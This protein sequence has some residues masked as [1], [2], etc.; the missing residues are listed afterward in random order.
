MEEADTSSTKETV[1]EEL[2]SVETSEQKKQ[3]KTIPVSP[4]ASPTLGKYKLN[5]SLSLKSRV[6]EKSADYNVQEDLSGK[7]KDPFTLDTLQNKWHAYCHT[8]K[9]EGKLGLYTT[10][11][12]NP[13]KL[14][15]EN[16]VSIRIDN[17]IQQVE[18]DHNKTDLMGF[19]YKELNNY[20]LTLK[21]DINQQAP[22][23]KHLTSKD[24]FLKMAKKNEALHT[25]RERLGLDIEY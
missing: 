23:T 21:I 8:L 4:K 3:E 2:P 19:L 1:T 20:S 17:K 9:K 24:K 13:V 14:I 12:K 7:P 11:S 25:L 15:D 18:I 6:R 5:S 16:I 22:E 10:L